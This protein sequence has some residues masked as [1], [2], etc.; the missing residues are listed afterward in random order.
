MPLPL[1]LA[2]PAA[3]VGAVS[4]GSGAGGQT[5]WRRKPAAKSL[6]VGNSAATGVLAAAE[7]ATSAA[8]Q[9]V[10]PGAEAV[11]APLAVVVLM[12]AAAR[13]AWPLP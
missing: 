9:R 5:T 8:E 10:A 7:L 2:G 6:A 11:P 1:L 12:A 4:F 13:L 3:W